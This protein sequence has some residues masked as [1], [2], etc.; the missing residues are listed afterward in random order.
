M[1]ELAQKT[2]N[3]F[4]EVA[5]ALGLARQG[6]VLRNLSR[7]ETALKLVR[8]AGIDSQKAWVV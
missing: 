8:V 4:D 1:V 5:E 7:V 2:G 3:A 6:L